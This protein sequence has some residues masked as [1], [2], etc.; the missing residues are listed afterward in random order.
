MG[1]ITGY[2]RRTAAIGSGGGGGAIN[3]IYSASDTITDNAR[4]VT[5]KSGGT[6]SQ[7]LQ[8]LN[9]GGG[10]LLK[11]SGNKA[12]DFGSGTHPINPKFY[13]DGDVYD[14]FSLFNKTNAN[15]FCDIYSTGNGFFNLK[16]AA[17]NS[18]IIMNAGVGG[19]YTETAEINI[20]GP[21]SAYKIFN[22]SGYNV[23]DLRSGNSDDGLLYIRNR[24]EVNQCLIAYGGS[25]ID[26]SLKVGGSFAGASAALQV[27]GPG[28][29]SATTTAL[30]QNSSSVPILT[31]T[32]DK[33]STFGGRVISISAPIQLNTASSATPTP[34][35]DADGQFNLTALAANATFGA[36]TGTPTGGQKLMIRI[37]DNG[38]ARTLAYN[39]IYRAIGITL[40]TTTVINKTLY[41]ACVYNAADTKWDVI[42]TAQEA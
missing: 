34:N 9:S 42:A 31:I 35:A 14:R 22:S 7:N 16:N 6:A 1:V 2:S 4:T 38:T 25:I 12:I 8:F 28:S 21:Y 3:T 18:K 26:T 39:A 41:I 17:G 15:S 40:P 27:V 11:L 13:L 19:V 10:N 5:L 32:D 30:F 33:V 24:F 29:T 23:V 20:S 36:P 37:K